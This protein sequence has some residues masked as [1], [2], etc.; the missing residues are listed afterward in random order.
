MKKKIFNS[1]WVMGVLTLAVFCLSACDREL[2]V[3][4]SY[5]FTVL[6]D[7]QRVFKGAR[8]TIQAPDDQRFDAALPDALEHLFKGRAIRVFGRKAG[9]AVHG[10]VFKAF[11]NAVG[12]QHLLLRLDR[13]A[14]F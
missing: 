9:I 4:Q 5:P 7:V 12:A 2:D 1:I 10:D 3:Q 6:D 8:E 14:F 11:N 13:V